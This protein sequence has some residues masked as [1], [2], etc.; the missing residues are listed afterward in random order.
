MDIAPLYELKTRLRAAAIAGTNLISEDFRLK[1]AAEEFKPLES[2]SPVFGKIGELTAALL[3]DS[4]SDKAGT[5]MDAITLADSV[6]CTLGAVGVKGEPEDIKAPDA[7]S[8]TIKDVPYSALSGVIK[9]LTSSGGGQYNAFIEV[10]EKSPEMFDD[11]RVKP[12]LVRGLGASYSELADEVEKTILTMGKEMLHPLKEGFDPKGKKEMLRRA[13]LIDSIGGADEN[14]FYLEQLEN[15]EKD[16]RE[17]LILALR[18]DKSNF[19]KLAELSNTEKG[20]MKKAA[21]S[22]MIMF[23]CEEA[24]E[25]FEKMAKKKPADV[26]E[27]ICAA[28]SEWSSELT[29]RLIDELLVDDK[30][31]KITFTQA[32]DVKKVKLK[33][34]NISFHTMTKALTGKFGAS[35]EKI[36]REYGNKATG[37]AVDMVFADS[38]ILTNNESLKKLAVEINNGSENKDHYVYAAAVARIIDGGDNSE[39][40]D[41]QVYAALKKYQKDQSMLI[42]ASIVCAARQIELYNGGYVVSM[43]DFDLELKK[44]V[45]VKRRPVDKSVVYSLTDAFVRYPAMHFDL[46]MSCWADPSDKEYCQRLVD[47]FVDHVVSPTSISLTSL[48]LLK[49]LNVG[50][51][52]GMALKFCE[53]HPE[54]NRRDLQDFFNMLPGDKDYVLGEARKIAELLKSGKLK[55]ALSDND[56]KEFSEW[57]EIRLT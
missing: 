49:E 55:M 20:K 2:A 10:R 47:V 23:D 44:L 43:Q 38:I 8:V 45:G 35:I 14:A 25:F 37:N 51:I 6:I 3:S 4:C 56:I 30:G 52:E 34:K 29:A 13:N 22:A 12:L 16:I 41:H 19:G 48:S 39:W 42:Y 7:Q 31:N 15:A 54:Y 24:A 21:L 33:D 18:H 11:F 9:A 40:F 53:N 27:L 57:I 26:L 1:K 28:S 17:R 46:I 50:N 32:A 5:M 36:Y